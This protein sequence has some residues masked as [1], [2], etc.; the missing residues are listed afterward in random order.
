MRITVIGAGAIG[1]A[2]AAYLH[3][4]GRD[5]LAVEA[6]P[7]RLSVAVARGFSISGKDKFVARVPVTTPEGLAAALGGRAP[8]AVILAVKSQHTKA[9]LE[10]L[11]PLLGP[12]SCVLSMQN[13]FN[14]RIVAGL[15]GTERTLAAFINTMGAYS[16]EPGEIVHGGPGRPYIG[17]LDGCLSARAAALA[18]LF[19]GDYAQQASA[20]ANIWGYL[21]GKEAYAAMFFVAAVSDTPMVEV[22]SD[23]ANRPFLTHLAAEVIR[24]AEAEGVR[25]ES[26]DGFDPDAMRREDWPAI[27]RTWDAVAEVTRRSPKPKSGIWLDLAVRKRKTEADELLG[28]VREIAADR[29]LDTPLLERL[30]G[31]VHAAERGERDIGPDVLVELRA[32]DAARYPAG[33][34]QLHAP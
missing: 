32:L 8:E 28:K 24:T 26:F 34:G 9:A 4:A 27:H 33:A 16:V 19:D 1:G 31:I 6:D 30:I 14:P 7:A 12:D 21:W 3:R 23:P 11:L 2:A 29:G 18:A 10:P 13:G 15:V 22:V 5:V 20:T 17:E 25:C